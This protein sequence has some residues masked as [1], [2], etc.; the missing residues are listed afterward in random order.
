MLS[1][2]G[3]V[4]W[5]S[6]ASQVYLR[7]IQMWVR[8]EKMISPSKQVGLKVSIPI[9]CGQL[10][11]FQW[12]K[13][14]S[15]FEKWFWYIHLEKCNTL[16]LYKSNNFVI[17]NVQIV[18]LFGLKKGIFLFS[19]FCFILL[20][21]ANLRNYNEKTWEKLSLYFKSNKILQYCWT[22]STL[23]QTKVQFTNVCCKF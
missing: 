6:V 5:N 4:P 16:C 10:T 21:S 8:L 3:H 2:L 1:R 20:T 22:F 17:T 7:T 14:K 19:L 11:R 12:N 9:L 15:V 18:L 23:M 13:H